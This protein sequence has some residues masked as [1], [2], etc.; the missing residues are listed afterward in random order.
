[1]LFTCFFD[2]RKA[3]DCIPRNKLLDKIESAGIKGKFLSILKS[4]YKD[5]RSAI[6]KDGIITKSFGCYSGVK[7]GCMLSPTLFNSFL[8]DLPCVLK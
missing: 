5:D 2:F 3:F 1:M 8:S 7:Q 6:E 4:M